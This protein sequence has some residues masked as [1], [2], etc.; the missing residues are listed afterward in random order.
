LKR[1]AKQREEEAS[2]GQS[3]N[4]RTRL[5]KNLNTLN[6]NA[7]NKNVIMRKFNNGNKNVTKLVEEAK[8]LKGYEIR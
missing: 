2:R 8:T 4:T 1:A 5:V 3:E 7:Q 6:L